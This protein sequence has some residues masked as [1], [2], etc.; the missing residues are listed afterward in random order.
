MVPAASE[1]EHLVVNGMSYHARDKENANSALVVSVTPSDYG[2]HPLAGLAFQRNLE[3][4][5]FQ[6]VE[7]AIM[8]RSRRWRIF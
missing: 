5:A 4:K 2:S 8:R 7:A 1:E 6:L 3:K